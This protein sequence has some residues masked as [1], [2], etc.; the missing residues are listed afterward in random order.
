M[1]DGTGNVGPEG[2]L[3]DPSDF[4]ANL[5]LALLVAG[6]SGIV[7]ARLGQS[8]I[9]GYIIAGILIGPYT[10]G[11]IADPSTV[12]AMADVGIVLLLFVTGMDVSPGDF[13][14]FGRVVG[15]GASIQVLLMVGLGYLVGLAL[16]W[17][18]IPSLFLGA[19]VS[20]SSSTVISK[21]LGERGESASRHGR[22]A[23]AWS[24]VQDLSTIVL[25]VLLTGIVEGGDSLPRDVALDVARAGLFLLVVV[26]LGTYLLPPVFESLRG[27]RQQEVFV[28]AAATLALLTAYT[29]TLFGL[30]PALGAFVAGVVLSESEIRHEVL[31]GIVP[32]RDVFA[33]L[34]FV[35]VGMLVEP[36]FVME[37]FGLVL[38]VFA[39]IVPVKALITAGFARLLGLSTRRSVL[40]G[41]AMGQSAEFSF[42]LVTLGASLAALSNTEFS[43]IL[44]ATAISTLTAP[45][46]LGL[47][48]P[49]SRSLER[50]E[51][52]DL[53]EAP[54]EP[55]S[56]LATA[57]R[58]DG[59]AIVA[60]HGRVGRIV[61]MALLERDRQVTVIDLDPTSVVELRDRGVPAF[62]GAADN[63][64]LLDLA[65]VERAALLVIAVPE[66]SVA[67][68]LT[69]MARALNPTIVIL[70]RTHEESERQHLE[71]IGADEALFG[72]LEL[73]IEMTRYALRGTGL[74]QLE[75]DAYV[76]DVR[77]RL[78]MG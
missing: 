12:N 57:A 24:A 9:L 6:V 18:P 52:R 59:H 76:E 32:L 20:N 43:V 7:A 38:V 28:L 41:G 25:V 14:R 66:R 62:L 65:G 75:V 4:L 19:V 13:R 48:T 16:G 49:L 77:H 23:L 68:R 42:L 8:V 27:L 61:T 78:Q 30:S 56:A 36:A 35:S 72:E 64:T 71:S 45:W 73:A 29:A 70:A 63:P 11:W 51:R 1:S 55:P 47:A 22:V 60:G 10:P 37:N 21:I 53:T 44:S 33:G 5:S 3:N 2:P 74:D 69:V 17:D 26:P 31:N 67:R 40:V 50:W 39:L 15:V 34:F 58:L 46:V 54:E